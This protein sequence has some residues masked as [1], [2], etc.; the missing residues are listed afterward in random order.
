MGDNTPASEPTTRVVKIKSRRNLWIFF[1]AFVLLILVSGLV[2]F[3]RNSSLIENT[4]K[5]FGKIFG[6]GDSDL[7]EVIDLNDSGAGNGSPVETFKQETLVENENGDVAVE[8][9]RVSNFDGLVE[10]TVVVFDVDGSD[11]GKESV[12]ITNSSI[13]DINIS[14]GSIQYLQSGADFLKIKKRNFEAGNTVKATSNFIVGMNCHADT[15]CVG[16]DISWS[17]A[18][19]NTGGA[20]FIVSDKEKIEGVIDVNI[21]SRYDYSSN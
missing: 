12:T 9:Q 8:E 1:G 5:T 18:L 13:S 7:V 19:N 15:P 14:A 21:V 11:L 16:A 17:E 3:Y 2:Y 6:R 10:I 20:V 4:G